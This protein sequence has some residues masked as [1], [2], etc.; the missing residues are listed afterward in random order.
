ML[1]ISVQYVI[2]EAGTVAHAYGPSYLEGWDWKITWAH[3]FKIS[4]DN[5][6]RPPSQKPK[7]KI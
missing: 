3:K 6:V 4:L 7:N 1:N 5:M 2:T